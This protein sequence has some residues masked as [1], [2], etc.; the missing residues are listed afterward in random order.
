[1]TSTN[2]NQA[3]LYAPK[4]APVLNL[5][6][7][8]AAKVQIIDTTSRLDV[9][10]QIFMGPKIFGH[11]ILKV[12]SFSF[13][14]EQVSSGRKVLFDLGC[15]KD[16]QSLPPLI[17]GLVTQPGWKIEVEKDSVAQILQDDGV[18]VASGAIEAIIWS[19]W[20]YDHTGDPST[21]PASTSLIVGPGVKEVFLPPYPENAQSPLLD[22]DFAGRELKVVDFENWGIVQIGR[23]R[24]IDYF[25]DG[26]FYILDAP[27]HAVGHLCALARVTSTQDGDVEGDTF[28][29]MGADAAHHGAELRP[30]Q[31]LPLPKTV[32][33]S[34][35]VSKY[36]GVCPGQLFEAIHP[37]HK[38]VEPFYHILHEGCG[39]AHHDPAQA[40]D[41]VGVVQEFDAA[42]NVF[43]VI[44][45]DASLLHESVGI[46]WF[47]RGSL[48]DWK[49]KDCKRKA[50][51][52]FLEDLVPA[53]EHAADIDTATASA[54][55]ATATN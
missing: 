33:P 17:L 21:F 53:V 38:A 14:V 7:G 18:D 34:P 8:A 5:P 28:V 43:V 23:F 39:V 27:G 32:S 51:W 42:D 11:E 6:P 12:P 4:P 49:T 9:P 26:S 31:Y 52:R 3:L 10:T 16:W 1:M 41:I 45:H 22:T 19:H 15:R 35:Y 48:R 30:T 37:R 50:R 54:A 25:N 40:Q 29:L 46:E 55:T 13:L 2:E 24:A 36:P 20:H 47:P 44:A